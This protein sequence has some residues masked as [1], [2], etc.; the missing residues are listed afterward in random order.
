MKAPHA[1][2]HLMRVSL[3]IELPSGGSRL[4]DT[5]EWDVS[6]PDNCPHHFAKV[7]LQELSLDSPDNVIAVANEIRH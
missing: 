1:K 4:Q 3:D 2:E 5:F 6:N 7:L